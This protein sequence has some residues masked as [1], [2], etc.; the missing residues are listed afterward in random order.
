ML[1]SFHMTAHFSRS[2]ESVC[3]ATSRSNEF[4]LSAH[5]PDVN[6]VWCLANLKFWLR[7]L[8]AAL[9]VTPEEMNHE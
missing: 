4:S 3:K 7:E 6:C 8:E 9:Q 2:G 1:T 5:I